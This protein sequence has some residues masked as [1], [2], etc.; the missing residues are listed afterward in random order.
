MNAINR[1]RRLN[2]ACQAGDSICQLGRVS[3]NEKD[4]ALAVKGLELLSRFSDS[5]EAWKAPAGTIECEAFEFLRELE[6]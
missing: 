3:V 5:Q 1:L 6:L 2:H 4:L